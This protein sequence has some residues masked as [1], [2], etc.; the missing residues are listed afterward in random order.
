VLLLLATGGK[1]NGDGSYFACSGLV[2]GAAT[3]KVV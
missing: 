2:T 1:F 3:L